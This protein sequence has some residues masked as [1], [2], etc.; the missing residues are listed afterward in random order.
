MAF[1]IGTN[2]AETLRG[3]NDADLL[4][5]R[6]GNDRLFGLAGNDELYG[7]PGA[8]QIDGG[9]GSDWV[10]FRADEEDGFDPDLQPAARV[11]LADGTYIVG[12]VV[13]RLTSIENILGGRQADQ[14]FGNG[15]A[16]WFSA[17]DGDDTLRG[18]GGNDRLDDGEGK[19]TVYGDGGADTIVSQDADGNDEL[20]AGAG[21]DHL[22]PSTDDQAWGDGGANKFQILTTVFGEEALEPLFTIR[23][24]SVSGGDLIDF[25]GLDTDGAGGQEG[26]DFI[27]GD[28]LSPNGIKEVRFEQRGGNTFVQYEI[29][30]EGTPEGVDINEIELSGQ[31]QL[32]ANDFILDFTS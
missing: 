14:F 23:D 2:A 11:D 21:N 22:V 6:G 9:N 12:G 17:Q 15:A 13:T 24:F 18:R 5:G 10:G 25:S 1:K 8:N 7:G 4:D 29:V 30:D 3:T 32:T 31:K 19:D 27:G 20:R 26:Y 16:N 28:E